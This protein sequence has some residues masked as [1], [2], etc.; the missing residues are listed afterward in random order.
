MRKRFY[1]CLFLLW[2][3]VIIIQ[4]A[5]QGCGPVSTF[6]DKHGRTWYIV[7]PAE[8]VPADTPTEKAD[9][10]IDSPPN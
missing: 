7:M 5:L 1:A 2:V 8:P 10:G 9:T 3:I 4:T 6:T